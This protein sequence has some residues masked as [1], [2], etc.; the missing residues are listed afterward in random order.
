M[1][2]SRAFAAEPGCGPAIQHIHKP[3]AP[4]LRVV[5]AVARDW[6]W[7]QQVERVRIGVDR[8]PGSVNHDGLWIREQEIGIAI[9]PCNAGFQEGRLTEIVVCRHL[10]RGAR[11]R[12]STG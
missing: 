10:N 12:S 7:R 11:A 9:K 2:R 1:G 6:V 5:V 4:E 3:H 8:N